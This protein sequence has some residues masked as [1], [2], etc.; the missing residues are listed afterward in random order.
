MYFSSNKGM[1][2]IRRANVTHFG[3]M[4]LSSESRDFVEFP[5][6]LISLVRNKWLLSKAG[7]NGD[8]VGFIAGF[9]T[10]FI[11]IC[12]Q[13]LGWIYFG[14]DL[15]PTCVSRTL[16]HSADRFII[17][18]LLHHQQHYH[19]LYYHRHHHHHLVVTFSSRKII[20]ATFLWKR[21]DKVAVLLSKYFKSFDC[22]FLTWI[23][24]HRFRMAFGS[25]V[26][27]L[28]SCTFN[29]FAITGQI[30]DDNVTIYTKITVNWKLACKIFSE[31]VCAVP[32][33][34]QLSEWLWAFL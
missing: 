26:M 18:H 24:Y 29:L 6:L 3:V 11:S 2:W 20:T 34:W 16:L 22:F 19:Q 17:S 10:V 30:T 31:L 23:I 28:V 4:M 25:H 32:L 15:S 1:I 13:R 14:L 12:A 8:P 33:A 27:Q 9:P 5:L 21:A 7:I